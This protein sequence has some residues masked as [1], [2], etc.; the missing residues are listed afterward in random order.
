MKY[1]SILHYN[2]KM[3]RVFFF[4]SD[5]AELISALADSPFCEYYELKMVPLCVLSCKKMYDYTLTQ[6]NSPLL[7]SCS[8]QRNPRWSRMVPSNWSW[9]FRSV[10]ITN[11]L[12]GRRFRLNSWAPD[13]FSLFDAWLS[14]REPK[15]YNFPAKQRHAY[16]FKGRDLSVSLRSEQVTTF[17]FQSSKFSKT[18]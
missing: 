1:L 13:I 8:W 14:H 15:K 18:T 7:L 5:S 9:T 16:L 10:E 17:M 4:Y 12:G 11:I 3:L 2:T 6:R